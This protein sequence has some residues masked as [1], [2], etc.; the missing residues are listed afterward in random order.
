MEKTIEQ[1]SGWSPLPFS[2]DVGL[3][4]TGISEKRR[5]ALSF[6]AFPTNHRL[7][8]KD[9]IRFEKI[10][11]CG[12]CGHVEVNSGAL[13][14]C[15]TCKGLAEVWFLFGF[16]H[17]EETKRVFSTIYRKTLGHR[18]KEAPSFGRIQGSKPSDRFSF[19]MAKAIISE[20]PQ[21]K[22]MS[23]GQIGRTFKKRSSWFYRLYAKEIS[24]VYVFLYPQ[25]GGSN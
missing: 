8:V 19:D 9:E 16:V 1:D 24:K 20:I 4:E 18:G 6:V 3:L 21:G 10:L 13:R 2:E 17:G 15:A 7:S 14:G 22:W 23:E 5:S 11:A 12:D 25:S